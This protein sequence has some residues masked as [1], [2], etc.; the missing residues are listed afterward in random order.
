MK[1]TVNRITS[2]FLTILIMSGCAQHV[3]AAP[4][5]TLTVMGYC[6]ADSELSQFLPDL[7]AGIRL[8]GI[9][10]SWAS[11]SGIVGAT[12]KEQLD[13][14]LTY[15]QEEATE[16]DG[17]FLITED[18]SES[19]ALNTLGIRYMYAMSETYR[20]MADVSEKVYLASSEFTFSKLADRKTS[21]ERWVFA[22]QDDATLYLNVAYNLTEGQ[23]AVWLVSPDGEIAYQNESGSTF[24]KD[25]QLDVS[26][27][28]WSVILV[29]HYSENYQMS[30]SKNI[31]GYIE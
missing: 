17:K 29:Q 19:E 2:L 12:Y 1:T 28:L 10:G 30:G 24:N 20:N 27:G 13:N 15:I 25:I 23:M 3:I 4:P 18:V 16:E 5:S 21:Y 6:P 31:Q 14:K 11:T 26:E 7:D 9:D 22:V 8:K